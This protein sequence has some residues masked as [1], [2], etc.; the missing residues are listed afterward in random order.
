MLASRPR[1]ALAFVTVVTTLVQ[2]CSS[3][4]T[5]IASV[6]PPA[7]TTVYVA[8][9]NGS[10][11]LEFPINGN[12]NIAPSATIAG[13]NTLLV[14]PDSLAV[15]SNGLVYVQDDSG[16]DIMIFNATGNVAPST[17]IS[18]AS[19]GLAASEG[20]AVDSALNIYATS[21]TANTLTSFPPGS[22]G[23]AAFAHQAVGAATGLTNATTVAIHNGTAYVTNTNSDTVVGLSATAD[24]N[25]AFTS[26]LSG[27]ATGL[28]TPFGIAFDGSG[29]MY[30]ANEAG[31]SVTVYAAPYNGNAAPIRT[32][33]GAATELNGPDAVAIDSAGNLYVGNYPSA[34]T[35]SIVV[36]SPGANGNATPIATIAGANT[37]L[38]GPSGIALH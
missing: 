33:S 27:A 34:G 12:G 35:N 25:Q 4:S 14:D 8:N 28:N 24:G 37:T 19:T 38:A 36:F 21:F 29:N 5:P 31:N 15:D 23:N 16:T 11:I 32:I 9:R 13:A 10:D 1:L 30:V 6:S 22:S 2:A 3:A 20:L 18:G 17:Q 7:A 26:L